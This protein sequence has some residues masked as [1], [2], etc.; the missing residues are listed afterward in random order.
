MVMESERKN[1]SVSCCPNENRTRSKKKKQK[2]KFKNILN[3]K[4]I[5]IL[6]GL[7]IVIGIAFV[8][9]LTVVYRYAEQNNC[10]SAYMKCIA[11]CAKLLLAAIVGDLVI[12]Y[13]VNWYHEKSKKDDTTSGDERINGNIFNLPILMG[14]LIIILLILGC[15][16]TTEVR[17]AV[18]EKEESKIEESN[19]PE[20]VISDIEI[21]L[22]N[23]DED[24]FM[25]V[26]SLQKYLGRA[27]ANEKITEVKVEV[28]LNNLQYNRPEGEQTENFNALR[29]TADAEYCAYLYM[30]EYEKK[31]NS[32]NE[33]A[34]EDRIFLLTKSL[35]NRVKADK[36]CELPENE[37]PIATGYKDLA[38]EFTRRKKYEDAFSNYELG[39]S[40]YMRTICHAAAID[41]LDEVKLCMDKF[42]EL[43]E[44][45]E[46]LEAVSFERRER[47]LNM[48]EVYKLFVD[49]LTK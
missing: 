46:K 20:N 24:P 22:Y 39:A 31:T 45:V 17:A 48:I 49:E 29:D 38:D 30:Y 16:I 36:E 14:G 2:D 9:L 27:I 26:K 7:I 37:R 23:V 47:I 11:D 5:E 34:F 6:L 8:S 18:L 13:G 12:S 21:S 43:G 32:F 35:D 10:L 40:W 33:G 42:E 28:L 4:K 15:I 1:G 19:S 44:E 41:N 25:E 3:N